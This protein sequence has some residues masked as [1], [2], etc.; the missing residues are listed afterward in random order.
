M[1]LRDPN[2]QPLRVIDAW[3]RFPVPPAVVVFGDRLHNF[4][5]DQFWIRM[6]SEVSGG[7]ESVGS[8]PVRGEIAGDPGMV[9]LRDQPE[10]VIDTGLE[11]VSVPQR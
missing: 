8:S 2:G 5:A 4:L 9:G 10:F 11:H 1:A 7:R 6:R 3:V